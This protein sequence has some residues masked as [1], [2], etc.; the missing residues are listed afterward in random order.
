M[1][2]SARAAGGEDGTQDV[3]ASASDPAPALSGLRVKLQP[4]KGGGELRLKAESDRAAAVVQ[5]DH[6][7]CS[8][9]GG[10]H[11]QAGPPE[12]EQNG[13]THRLVIDISGNQGQGG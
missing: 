1:Q 6:Q 11:R 8:P 3:A 13:D 2:G 4:A 7:A 5:F 10:E 9:A 12:P